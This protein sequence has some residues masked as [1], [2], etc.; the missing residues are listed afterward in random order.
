MKKIGQGLQFNVYDQGETVRKTYTT[1]LQMIVIL[2]RWSPML[3]FNIRLLNKTIN[4]AIRERASAICEI[5]RRGIKRSLLANLKHDGNTIVQD[6]VLV[7]GDKLSDNDEAKTWIDKYIAFIIACWKNGFSE[8]TYNFTINNGTT[9]RGDVV[10]MDIG[11]ITFK[12]SEIL[13][14]IESKRWRTSWSYKK[15]LSQE[16]RRY[17]DK[18]MSDNLTQKN[19]EKYWKPSNTYGQCIHQ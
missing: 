2:I 17:Y 3:L 16:L 6:K 8:K 7:L 12:R 10:L 1:K 5:E 13:E 4:I 15:D 9:E 19:F 14:A 18:A 11:E